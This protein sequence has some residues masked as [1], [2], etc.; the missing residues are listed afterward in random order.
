MSDKKDDKDEKDRIISLWDWGQIG[1][2]G[3]NPG[4]DS[5]GNQIQLPKGYGSPDSRFCMHDWAI[6]D[7]GLRKFYYC[8]LCNAKGEDI[9]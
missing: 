4:L 2:Y 8:K 3:Y 6:Y 7:S 5:E 1:D 9:F